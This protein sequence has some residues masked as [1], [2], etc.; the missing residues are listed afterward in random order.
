MNVWWGSLEARPTLRMAV[1]PS[2]F[3][4]LKKKG[5]SQESSHWLRLG[6]TIVG[7]V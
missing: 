4:I 5:E 1:N 7:R 3:T 6:R 2:R